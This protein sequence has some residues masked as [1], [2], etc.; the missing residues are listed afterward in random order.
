MSLPTAP[1]AARTHESP[2]NSSTISAPNTETTPSSTVAKALESVPDADSGASKGSKAA[3]GM[4]TQV[5]EAAEKIF[6]QRE[7]VF[8]PK[9]NAV[10]F[11]KSRQAGTGMRCFSG[12]F[13]LG[14]FCVVYAQA[15]GHVSFA[16]TRA[17]GT[18]G[19]DAADEALAGC[20]GCWFLEGISSE[21]HVGIGASEAGVE[22]FASE[23]VWWRGR[24]GVV[25]DIDVG[26]IAQSGYNDFADG[27]HG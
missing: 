5:E 26:H 15:C 21:A 2:A 1:S 8:Q 3:E 13:T 18:V 23:L 9:I 14:G 10:T 16:E 4:K 7:T 20:Q 19:G 17:G 11:C 12:I 24:E 6:E 25:D 22:D 27:G